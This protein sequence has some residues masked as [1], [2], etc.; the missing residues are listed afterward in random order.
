[1]THPYFGSERPRVL[2]H[3]GFVPADSEGIVENTFAAFAAAHA[4]GVRYVESDCHLSADGTVILFHDSDLSRVAGDPRPIADVGDRELED[5]M[6]DRG[7]LVTLAQAL[8]AFPTLFFNLDVKTE[9]AAEKVGRLVAPHADRV[10]VTSF[11]DRTRER[12]L[13]AAH[14]AG[15]RPATSAGTIRIAAL[16]AAVASGVPWLMGRA[17]RGIDAVQ[18][19]E[20]R[21]PIRIVSPRMIRA[22]HRTGVEM[23]VWTVNDAD[24]MRRL[25]AAG[26]DGIVTDRADRAM[27]IVAEER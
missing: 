20:R 3:R 16:V 21:G 27:T 17:L 7:G 5:L 15:G 25:L 4:L 9:S 1:M 13:R 11:S 2:A 26:V 22:V 18:V 10:L 23:H 19:P 6:A 8:D 14:A 24:G 12:A